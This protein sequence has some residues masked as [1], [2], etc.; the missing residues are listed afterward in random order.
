M[1]ELREA[2]GTAIVPTLPASGGE[3]EAIFKTQ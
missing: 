1:Q 2:F 3:G